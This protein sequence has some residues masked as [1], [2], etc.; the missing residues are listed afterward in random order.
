MLI[1]YMISIYF[2]YV[3]AIWDIC[4]KLIAFDADVSVISVDQ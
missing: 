1:I 4:I 2:N 3:Y